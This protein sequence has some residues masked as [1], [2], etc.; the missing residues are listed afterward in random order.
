MN[1]TTKQYLITFAVTA[2]VH[3]F[4]FGFFNIFYNTNDDVGMALIAKG[5]FTG[6]PE[7]HLVFINTVWGY[8][9]KFLYQTFPK[10]E[11]YSL[12]L[13]G[14]QFFSI[15]AIA[16]ILHGRATL[17]SRAAFW[18]AA[19][20]FIVN[21]QF[22]HVAY[23]AL[24]AG[25]LI[26]FTRTKQAPWWQFGVGVGFVF[27][28][29]LLRIDAIATGIFISLPF[30]LRK[31]KRY[32]LAAASLFVLCAVSFWIHLKSYDSPS[33]RYF[34]EYNLVRGALNDNP[35]IADFSNDAKAL[36]RAGV[37]SDELEIF[38]NSTP[39]RHFDLELLKKIYSEVKLPTA[40]RYIKTLFLSYNALLVFIALALVAFYNRSQ[41][42]KVKIA[43][44]LFSLIVLAICLNHYP[45][46][47]VL[48]DLLFLV[49]L[50]SLVSSRG[51]SKKPLQLSSILLLLFFG[52]SSVLFLAKVNPKLEFTQPPQNNTI[53][54]YS[55]YRT[56]FGRVKPFDMPQ[57]SDNKIMAASWLVDSQVQID[58]YEKAG[59]QVKQHFSPMENP[60]IYGK[61][62]FL[63]DTTSGSRNF[64]DGPMKRYL[65]TQKLQV[66]KLTTK[67]AFILYHITANDTV[68]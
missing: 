41:Y 21:L 4:C 42:N 10:W 26:L 36:K 39:P 14:V 20:F 38:N 55:N 27:I 62:L 12:L 24:S 44:I 23:L 6:S 53:P 19:V 3:A 57:N 29:F 56:Y 43:L 45:K 37:T 9:L 5:Y 46:D 17:L 1:K 65:Q 31:D 61:F 16:R 40:A 22:T 18:M 8:L 52:V 47:R 32:I 49:F 59:V 28:A 2:V 64:V 54:L 50:F 7:E 30:L 25:L 51:F 63:A 48:I 11:W 35:N 66:H 15:A 13:T 68:Q 67:D 33:W 58:Q 34:Q 60:E